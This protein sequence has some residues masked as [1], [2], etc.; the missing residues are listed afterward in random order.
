MP[1]EFFMSSTTEKLPFLD[2]LIE[3]FKE[4]D[5]IKRGFGPFKSDCEEIAYYFPEHG[6]RG[7]SIRIT[8]EGNRFHFAFIQEIL[9]SLSDWQSLLSAMQHM[10]DDPEYEIRDEDRQIIDRDILERWKDED[11]YRRR[12]LLEVRSL[13]AAWEAE[14]DSLAVPT[15]PYDLRIERRDVDFGA[16]LEEQF[17]QIQEALKRQAE[18]FESCAQPAILQTRDEE[19]AERDIIAWAPSVP[20]L[21]WEAD[22]VALDASAFGDSLTIAFQDLLSAL[23]DRTRLIGSFIAGRKRYEFPVLDFSKPKDLQLKTKILSLKSF[24]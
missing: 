24:F 21:V 7:F 13:L 23:G 11:I 6:V 10:L 4:L 9:P 18:H 17:D 2:D 15:Y 1:M 16:S 8:Q 20:T 12:H 5:I 3:D 14:A 19:G 22:A